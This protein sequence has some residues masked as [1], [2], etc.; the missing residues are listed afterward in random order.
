MM[1]ATYNLEYYRG[2]DLRFILIPKD[3]SGAPLDLSAATPTFTIS[4]GRGDS[5]V[6]PGAGFPATI[7]CTA[8]TIDSN[9]K[10]ECII[11]QQNGL[12][13][14]AGTLYVYDVAISSGGSVT[15]YLTGNVNVTERVVA[16]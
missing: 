5:P 9:T 1:P 3:S 16:P 13:M 14:K 12:D 2:D 8:S 7:Q 10:I 6:S 11:T 15:T 4:T